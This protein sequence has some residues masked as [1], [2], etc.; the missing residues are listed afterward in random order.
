MAGKGCNR[1]RKQVRLEVH[2]LEEGHGG[3]VPHC[4]GSVGGRTAGKDHRELS[5]KVHPRGIPLTA[6]I[7]VTESKP[8]PVASK[9]THGVR[10]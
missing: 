9:A 1:V 8:V 5:W 6:A 10:E 4:S 3:Q 7:R 2:S